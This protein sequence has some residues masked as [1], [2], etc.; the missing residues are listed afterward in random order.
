MSTPRTEVEDWVRN[1]NQ[2]LE[3]RLDG[4]LTVPKELVEE[5][6]REYHDSPLAGH[7]GTA[8]VWKTLSR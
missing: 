4:K 8:K 1:A 7:P 6:L 2:G 5:L 3:P